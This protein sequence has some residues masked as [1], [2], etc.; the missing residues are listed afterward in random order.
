V[1]LLDGRKYTVAAPGTPQK[2][3]SRLYLDGGAEA[4]A[5]TG[6]RIRAVHASPHAP[7]VDLFAIAKTTTKVSSRLSFGQATR[8]AA[9]PAGSYGLEVRPTGSKTVVLK[10]PS[11]SLKAGSVYSVYV[12]GSAKNKTLQALLTLD[13]E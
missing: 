12:V 2:V 9:T 7:E 4:E 1:S 13:S 5:P 3:S 8:Y 6:V 11:V 10:V